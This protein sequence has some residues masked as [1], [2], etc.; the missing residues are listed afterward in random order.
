[1]NRILYIFVDADACP[2][3]PQ[4]E[5]AARKYDV[6]VVLLCDTNHILTSDYSEVRVVG[7]GPDAVDL[8]L[9]N[10]CHAGDIVV[11]QDYGVAAL[12][13]GKHAYAVHQNGWQYTDE[14]IDRLLME[15][16]IMKKARR[17]SSKFHGKG[18][19]K[20]TV[21]DNETF[22]RKFEKLLQLLCLLVLSVLGLFPV[23]S[24]VSAAAQMVQVTGTAREGITAAT[25]G[26][27]IGLSPAVRARAALRNRIFLKYR[28]MTV[29]SDDQYRITQAAIRDNRAHQTPLRTSELLFNKCMHDGRYSEAAITASLAVLDSSTSVDCARFTLL[30]AEACLLRQDDLHAIMPL[31]QQAASELAAESRHDAAW[32][33]ARAMLDELQSGLSSS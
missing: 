14:N 9:I 2:V 7:A 20:R 22:A 5:S 8:A 27:D 29:I 26:R 16:H 15:R 6:P 18:L 10:L 17:T 25:G 21:A 31:L 13:L 33:Q 28:E 12:A 3:V 19:R 1:M 4:I 24:S 23:S 30:Q 11:T 32:Q